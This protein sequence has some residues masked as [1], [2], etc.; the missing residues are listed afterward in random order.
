LYTSPYFVHL[1]GI[2]S[3]LDDCQI[4]ALSISSRL[5]PLTLR[6]HKSPCFCFHDF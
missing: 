4:Y 5:Q 2:I 1:W 3:L 6:Y